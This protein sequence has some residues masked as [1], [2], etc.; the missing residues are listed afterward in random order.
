MLCMTSDLT[1]LVDN[2]SNEINS[3]LCAV[4][5]V[6]AVEPE[7]L[8]KGLVCLINVVVS[9]RFVVTERSYMQKSRVMGWG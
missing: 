3:A 9:L 6:P 4:T 7:G 5:G 2:R 8:N 1:A